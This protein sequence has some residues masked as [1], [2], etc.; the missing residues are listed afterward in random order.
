MY[1]LDEAQKGVSGKPPNQKEIQKIESQI[2]KSKELLEKSE[3]KYH[4]A[5][6][7]V[8][9]ARQDWQIEMIQSCCQMQAIESDRISALE[10]LIKKLSIQ[11][12]LLSRKVVKIADVYENIKINIADDIALACRKFGTTLGNDQ[13]LY[14]YDIYAEN[15]KNMMN[16]DRRIYNLTKWNEW[17]NADIQD[18]VKAKQGMEKLRNFA[19]ENPKFSNSNNEADVEI[20]LKSVGLMQ[21]LFA[22]SQFKVQSALNELLDQPKPATQYTNMITTY[23]KQVC[24]TT[25]NLYKFID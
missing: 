12:G 5:C 1:N 10:Q 22:S 3:Q 16:K 20:K 25:K 21:I 4:K 19:L 15:T 13:E 8:E 14:M 11:I 18:Q 17:L 23:D 9:L 7:A 2:V 6:S 24:K